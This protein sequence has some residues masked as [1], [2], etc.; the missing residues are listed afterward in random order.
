ME[1][2]SQEKIWFYAK[3]YGFGWG[4][5]ASWEGWIV[6]ITYMAILIGGVFVIPM[7]YY[8]IAAVCATLMLFLILFWKG[9]KLQWRFG[10]NDQFS[11]K[12][13]KVFSLLV[14]L[15]L[16][17]LILTLGIWLYCN[18]PQDIGNLGY[19]TPTSMQNDVMWDEAQ[20]YSSKVMIIAASISL[21]IQ[22]ISYFS[23]KPE[24]SLLVSVV[25]MVLAIVLV[26]PLTELHLQNYELK[27][28]PGLQLELVDP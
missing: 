17:P 6:L 15:L 20:V 26:I 4:M 14:H 24:M 23:M 22:I 9:E 27:I 5:P 1:D 16:S 28:N 10:K 21:L 8:A 7:M 11:P 19:R 2:N 13:I 12:Q 25:G 3:R 18:P